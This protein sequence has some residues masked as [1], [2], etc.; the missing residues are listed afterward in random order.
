MD[1]DLAPDSQLEGLFG[2]LPASRA[3][4]DYQQIEILGSCR[5]AET[6]SIRD[7]CTTGYRR[8]ARGAEIEVHTARFV[9]RDISEAESAGN[10]SIRAA[11][12][13]STYR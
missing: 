8:C 12:A 1:G 7:R 5:F 6:A 11:R 3:N 4:F 9:L 2:K 13:A 10:A